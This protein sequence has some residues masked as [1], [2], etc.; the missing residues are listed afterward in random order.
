[1]RALLSAFAALCF[2][3]M[4]A[5]AADSKN[6]ESVQGRPNIIFIFSDDHALQ[7]ISA[8][9]G[10][11]KDIA[12]TPHIDRIAKEG[13]L[14]ERS[15]CGNSICGPSRATILTG[16]HTHI[17]GFMDNNSSRFDG[18][19]PTFPK[20]LQRV[21]YETAIIGKWHL[22]SNPT[23]FDHWEI[24]PGQGSYFAPDFI[25]MDGKRQRVPGYCTDLITDKSIEW[26]RNRKDKD[27][28]FILMSQHKAPHRHWFP[29]ARHFNLFDEI[30]MPE[31]PTLFDNYANRSEV[32]AKQQMSIAHDFNWSEDMFLHGPKADP[33]FSDGFGGDKGYIGEYKRMTP[34]EQKAFDEAYGAENQALIDQLAKGMSDE[35]LT[36][37]KYQRYMKNYLRC[38]RALDENIGRLLDYLD[39]SGL[40]KNT[41]V[42]YSADQGFYLGEH[43][44]YDKRWM[45]EESLSMPFLIRWPGVIQPGQRSQAMI[46]NID[47]APTFLDL[48]GAPVPA[49]MQG[50]SLVPVLKAQGKAPEGWRDAI[51]YQYS[52]EWTHSVARHEGV[53]NE[54]Y[55]LMRFPDSDE[56]M[57]FDLQQDPQEL[58]NL[59]GEA[60]SAAVLGKMKTL[61]DKLR[62]QYQVNPS[63]FP[64]Q[65][66]EQKW[67]KERWGAKFAEAGK[68][69]AQ[70]AK[71][72]FIG[73]SITQG[74]E[75]EG[76]AEWDKRFAP[77]GALNWGFSGD[78]TE[79]VIWRLQNGELERVKPE[80]AVLMI[81]TNNTGHDLRPAQETALGIRRILDDLAWKWPSTKIVLTAIFPRGAGKDDPM[82][83]R[84]EEINALIQPL[85]DGKRVFWHDLNGR[86][87]D[88]KG[89]LGKEFMPDLLHL[90]GASYGIW[91]EA[92]EGKLKELGA[93]K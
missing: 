81:G 27:K 69:A 76:K 4:A 73:D 66:L 34:D 55:K 23:G 41:I 62:A 13:M 46:Q 65:R 5:S 80:V 25:G 79:H 93:G 72:V 64:R 70:Q 51:Y 74:W 92:L 16:K 24:L 10:R 36:R 21:G 43:G 50:A 31:P 8:Y 26:L 15:Y 47:Y 9:G 42:I 35:E 39:E 44:W 63:T 3:C 32:L 88:E 30:A 87:L 19:Q 53:R 56:W 17:N 33:R 18:A 85:A 57:L 29:P 11:F 84:N 89:V 38:V 86:F 91:G 82:R 40:A 54:R 12:P 48:C 59:A 60:S 1:M 6:P 22:I 52:G 68:P 77:L 45:F 78:R 20:M 7:A 61:F 71:V 49:D 75:G 83:L 67:W 90:N 58:R 14:F 37:W 2:S 28:P